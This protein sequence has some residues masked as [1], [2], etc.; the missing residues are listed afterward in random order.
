MA[1]NSETMQTLQLKLTK[2]I[3]ENMRQKTEYHKSLADLQKINAELREKLEGYRKRE[4]ITATDNDIILFM[5]EEK[6][7]NKS[8]GVIAK[9]VQQTF[10]K[11]MGAEEVDMVIGNVNDLSINMQQFYRD[12]VTK[13]RELRKTDDSLERD[14]IVAQYDYHYNK[15][16]ILLEKLDVNNDNDKKLY[17]EVNDKMKS[18]LNEKGKI[19]GAVKEN[20]YA[21]DETLMRIARGLNIIGNQTEDL[22]DKIM[23]SDIAF[24]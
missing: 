17:I 24:C 11:D 7:K 19:V 12:C 10:H 2:A 20:G 21:P 23:P 6:A 16:S 22:E 1:R 9:L 14:N 13:Y 4:I 5:L 8:I 15:L 18:I 3:E